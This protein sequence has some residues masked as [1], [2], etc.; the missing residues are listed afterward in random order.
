VLSARA[1]NLPAVNARTTADQ[2]IPISRGRGYR[3][4]VQFG[5]LGSIEVFEDGKG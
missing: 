5:V 4:P 2:G 3:R 1:P